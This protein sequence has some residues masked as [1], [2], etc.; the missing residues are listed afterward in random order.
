MR[1]QANTDFT[2]PGRGVERSLPNDYELEPPYTRENLVLFQCDTCNGGWFIYSPARGIAIT[3]E[4]IPAE[5]SN[6]D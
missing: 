3:T 4:I 1:C 2:C 5:E 6:N